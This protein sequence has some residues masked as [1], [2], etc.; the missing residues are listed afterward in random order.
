V[1]DGNCIVDVDC[2]GECGGDAVEDECGECGGDGSS[3]TD[4][5]GGEGCDNADVCL[6]YLDDM[7]GIVYSSTEDI[8]GFQFAHNGCVESAYGGDAEANDFTISSSGTMVLAFSFT[9]SVIPATDEGVL[10][11]LE[12][13][14]YEDCLDDFVF[15]GASGNELVVGF[16]DGGD[17]GG[18][19]TQYFTD[20]PDQTGE[21]SLIIIQ[22]ALGLDEGDE[23]GLFDTDGVVETDTTGNNPQYGELLVASGVWN[24]EQL[25]LVAVLSIDLSDFSG[26]ILNGAVEGNDIVIKVWDQDENIVSTPTASYTMGD[27]TYGEVLTVIDVLDA[28]RYGCTDEEAHQSLSVPLH[29]FHHP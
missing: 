29:K 18:A 4:D 28:Y 15:S 25:E 9:G 19:D 3:C 1:F 23:V 7:G 16:D 27:G 10:V 2:N 17:D 14:V 8:A 13:D 6:Y 24:N 22:N 20:L 21:S 5:G 26:P 11:Y 12:G